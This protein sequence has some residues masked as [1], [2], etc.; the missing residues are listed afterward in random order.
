MI[1]TIFVPFLGIVAVAVVG[2]SGVYFGI[3]SLRDFMTEWHEEMRHDYAEWSR[4][5]KRGKKKQ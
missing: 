4:A 5:R 1:E 2:V 3:T